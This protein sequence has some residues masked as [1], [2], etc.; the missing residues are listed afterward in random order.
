MFNSSLHFL[1]PGDNLMGIENQSAAG[2]GPEERQPPRDQ[3]LSYGPRRAAD[4]FGSL[5]NAEGRAKLWCARLPVKRAGIGSKRRKG[6]PWFAP[7]RPRLGR[8][9]G[10]AVLPAPKGQKGPQMR[11]FTHRAYLGLLS[12]PEESERL[13]VGVRS[14]NVH[15][16]LVWI[17]VN[18]QGEESPQEVRKVHV[19]IPE[20]CQHEASKH[21]LKHKLLIGEEDTNES[22]AEHNRDAGKDQAGQRRKQSD[23][24][25]QPKRKARMGS[26]EF[27]RAALIADFSVA[28]IGVPVRAELEIV[29]TSAEVA[30]Q[31]LAGSDSMTLVAVAHGVFIRATGVDL[32][33]GGAKQA[34]RC[35]RG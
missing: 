16:R 12:V 2:R 24:R 11:G 1:N 18:S 5:T 33:R 35:R 31:R 10:R 13:P 17:L 30:E 27:A 22:D 3:G 8:A 15:G 32:P 9:M 25:G 6:R 29:G 4:E 7:E 20:E 21:G 23:Q 26:R 19:Q 14:F 28:R 34:T